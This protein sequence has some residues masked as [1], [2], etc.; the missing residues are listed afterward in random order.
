MSSSITQLS[1]LSHAKNHNKGMTVGLWRSML[2]APFKCPCTKCW[3]G[4]R[5]AHMIPWSFFFLILRT[6]FKTAS[7]FV[8]ATL[9][10]WIV[11]TPTPVLLKLI[12]CIKSYLKTATI[13]HFCQK[14]LYSCF[15]IIILPICININ[16]FCHCVNIFS[17]S[18]VSY[19]LLCLFFSQT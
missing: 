10:C 18:S 9:K 8:L 1:R 6:R 17:K 15:S 7:E 5:R 12:T 11:Y 2:E 16:L 13:W 14:N 3:D 4:R 19:W